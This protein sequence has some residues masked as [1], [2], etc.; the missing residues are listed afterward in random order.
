MTRAELLHLGGFIAVTISFLLALVG[1]RFGWPDVLIIPAA[2][3]LAAGVL[4]ISVEDE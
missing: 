2:L 3:G 1:A 4:A